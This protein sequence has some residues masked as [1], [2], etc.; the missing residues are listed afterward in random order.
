MHLPLPHSLLCSFEDCPC[1]HPQDLSLHAAP[2]Q[3]VKRPRPA[4]LWDVPKCPSPCEGWPRGLPPSLLP[5]R[6]STRF[7]R[8]LW[9]GEAFSTTPRSLG[10]WMG[11]PGRS[12]TVQ[13]DRSQG[14]KCCGPRPSLWSSPFL[15]HPLCFGPVVLVSALF[16]I[17]PN[18]ALPQGLCILCSLE[19][20]L[21]SHCMAH[22]TALGFCS[23]VT[24][25]GGGVL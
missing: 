11:R 6:D 5:W 20:S 19:R 15:P 2:L 13:G 7:P 21:P 24:S 17:N 16:F 10:S 8:T 3:R 1:K 18:Y 25:S 12:N 22:S 9:K 23:H 14:P 4:G